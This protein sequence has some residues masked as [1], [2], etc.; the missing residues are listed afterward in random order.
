MSNSLD[1]DRAPHFVRSGLGPDCLQG[2]SV[3]NTR[4]QRVKMNVYPFQVMEEFF[5]SF[6]HLP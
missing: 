4:R 6:Y 1:P 5:L 2:L 3:D